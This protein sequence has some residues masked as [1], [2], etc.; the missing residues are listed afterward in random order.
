MWM[1]GGHWLFCVGNPVWNLWWLYH[2]IEYIAMFVFVNKALWMNG[3]ICELPIQDILR[4]MPIYCD[5]Q[6]VWCLYKNDAHDNL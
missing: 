5:S 2:T 3:L 1:L 6:E 4:A